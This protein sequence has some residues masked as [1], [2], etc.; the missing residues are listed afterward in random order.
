[1]WVDPLDGTSE[2][3]QGLLDHVTVLI[4]IAVGKEPVAG[5]IHQPFYNYQKGGELGR[6]VWGL[7]GA[8]VGGISV[9][10]PPE[11]RII[12]TTRSHSTGLVD[13]VLQ[14]CQPTEVL[15]VGGAGHKV[16]TMDISIY[17]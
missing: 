15:R 11:G 16:S 12:A 8:G 4:G 13:Q 17:L 5:V 7:R 10:V 6:T 1:M 14:A 2:Y 3:T 9:H